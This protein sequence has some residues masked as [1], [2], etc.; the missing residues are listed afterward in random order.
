MEIYNSNVQAPHLE[1][2]TLPPGLQFCYSS[3]IIA[4]STFAISIQNRY[5]KNLHFFGDS[6]DKLMLT[7][8]HTNTNLLGRP[9]LLLVIVILFCE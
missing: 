9:P 4:T 3:E 1:E 7:A 8:I 5:N 6:S 2:R